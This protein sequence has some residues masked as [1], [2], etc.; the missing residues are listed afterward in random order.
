LVSY[1]HRERLQVFYERLSV[2]PAFGSFDEAWVELAR[3]LTEVED[4]MSGV[5][6]NPDPVNAPDDGRMYPP[7]VDYRVASECP[8]VQIFR[9]KGHRTHFGTNG[10]ILITAKG[11]AVFEKAGRDQR[12]VSDLL[13]DC[14]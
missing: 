3:V 6:C 11:I 4:E 5:P 12:T 14:Q 2:L 1:S 9:H 8:L 7:H 10:A 13:K